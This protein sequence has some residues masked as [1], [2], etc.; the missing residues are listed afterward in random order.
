MAEKIINFLK[1]HQN[2][3]ILLIGVILVSLFSFAMGYIAARQQE[4]EPIRL[5]QNENSHSWS[6]NLRF[7][8]GLEVV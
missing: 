1:D 6:G 7:V 5:E 3:I 8:S 2:D 4:K